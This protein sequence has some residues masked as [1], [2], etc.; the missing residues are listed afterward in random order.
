MG[1]VVCNVTNPQGNRTKRGTNGSA[2]YDFGACMAGKIPEKRHVRADRQKGARRDSGG[3]ICVRVGVGGYISTQQTQNKANR[4]T[5][6]STGH[7]FGK[8]VWGK[9]FDKDDEVGT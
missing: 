8:G 4:D 5:D 6:R 2:R 7:N 1:V 9:L 3:W